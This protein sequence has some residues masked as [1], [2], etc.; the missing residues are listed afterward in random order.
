MKSK[1]GNHK[2]AEPID[3]DTTK[4]TQYGEQQC[5]N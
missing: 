4:A 3:E 1:R 2:E 5:E